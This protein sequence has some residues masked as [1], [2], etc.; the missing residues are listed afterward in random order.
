MMADANIA[1]NAYLESLAS[2]S[3]LDQDRA[4]GQHTIE[5]EFQEAGVRLQRNQDAADENL[6]LLSDRIGAF[7]LRV[8]QFAQS[9]GAT[10][11]HAAVSETPPR[12][13]RAREIL[14]DQAAR[15]KKAEE[16]RDWVAR[17]AASTAASAE[18]GARRAESERLEDQARLHELAAAEQAA[19]DAASAAGAKAVAGRRRNLILI[20]AAVV[21][22]I[23]VVVILVTFIR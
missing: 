8:R 7:A 18:E 21:V 13:D 10:A 19:R 12:L 22:V 14:E 17:Y 6:K 9:V 23:G 15:L 2:L 11:S 4:S 3:S 1:W 20:I 16:A 5:Q